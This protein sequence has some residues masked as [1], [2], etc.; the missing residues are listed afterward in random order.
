MNKAAINI[1][2]YYGNVR[3]TLKLIASF[4]N[5]YYFTLLPSKYAS[6]NYSISLPTFGSS[7]F[8]ILGILVGVLMVHCSFSLHFPD[9]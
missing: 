9:D 2:R 8:L 4:Q 1:V 3:L 5:M 7:L 6:S